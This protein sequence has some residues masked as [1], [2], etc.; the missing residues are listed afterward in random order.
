MWRMTSMCNVTAVRCRR[1]V[2][3][4]RLRNGGP[5]PKESLWALGRQ[6]ETLETILGALG[7]ILLDLLWTCH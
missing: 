1:Q 5:H 7:P 3:W 6:E 4:V 2:P